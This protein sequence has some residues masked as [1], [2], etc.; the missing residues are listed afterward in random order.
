MKAIT[1]NEATAIITGQNGPVYLGDVI[2]DN[3][4]RDAA[5]KISTTDAATFEVMAKRLVTAGKLTKHLKWGTLDSYY[6]E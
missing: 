2:F 1:N 4:R 3:A 5:G 6:Y